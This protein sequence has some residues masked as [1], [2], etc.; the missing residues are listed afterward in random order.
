M[1]QQSEEASQQAEAVNPVTQEP[2]L[3]FGLGSGDSL[4]ALGAASQVAAGFPNAHQGYY[5]EMFGPD[6][7]LDW[8]S[9]WM[10]DSVPQTEESMTAHG[11][12]QECLE[13]DFDGH[14]LVEKDACT[15]LF[16]NSKTWL[17]AGPQI[18][19]D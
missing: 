17:A 3:Q 4:P 12:G 8:E 2:R 6:S 13:P 16:N 18:R 9:E 7:S 1:V 15:A 14:F 10:V 19:Y 11:A 5:E